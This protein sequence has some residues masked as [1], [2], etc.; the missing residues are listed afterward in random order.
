[1]KVSDTVEIVVPANSTTDNLLQGRRFERAPFPA[2]ANFYI[3]GS[4]AGLQAEINVGGQSVTPR[5]VVN[6]QNRVP[7]VPDDLWVG[8]VEVD[9]GELVQVTGVNTTAGALTI[10]LK[11]ELEEAEYESY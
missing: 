4:A 7:T 2:F 10:R 5:S 1:M 9:Q 6:S 8:D 11:L 3:T